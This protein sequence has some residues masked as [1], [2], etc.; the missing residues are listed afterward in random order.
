MSNRER[1]NKTY[2]LLQQRKRNKEREI[3]KEEKNR[4]ICYTQ[5]R[6]WIEPTRKIIKA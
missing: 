3:R 6:T 2:I 4:I 1:A 5:W